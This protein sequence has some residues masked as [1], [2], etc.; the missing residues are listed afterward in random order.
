M[1]WQ[2][3][4]WV[5]ALS[6]LS[7]YN[8]ANA[9]YGGTAS[10]YLLMQVCTATKSATAPALPGVV[11]GDV[12]CRYTRPIAATDVP[13]YTM[14]DFAPNYVVAANPSCA[15]SFGPLVRTSAPV[16]LN[17]LTRMVTFNQSASTNQCQP[18]AQIGASGGGYGL[19]VQ[20]QDPVTGYASIMGSSGPNAI[21][22]NDAYQAFA[23]GATTGG[24]PS[25]PVCKTGNPFSSARFNNSWIVG[26]SPVSKTLPSPVQFASVQLQIIDPASYAVL[27]S[28]PAACDTPYVTG[29]HIW[30]T[31]WYTFYSGRMNVA[32]IAAHYSSSN[33][34]NTGPGNAQQ[35]ER[36]YWTHEFGL[37]R[38]EKWTRSDLLI[39]GADPKTLSSAL[40]QHATCAQKGL[41]AGTPYNFVTNPADSAVSGNVTMSTVNGVSQNV[42]SG[43]VT[44]TWYMTLCNDY[45]NIDR[46]ATG[47]PAP[48]ISSDYQALWTP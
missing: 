1:F 41:V 40:L 45:T 10:D 27:Q 36:T 17:G 34:S 5:V 22:L 20:S 35:M 48:A 18:A 26:S 37:S 30:R 21:S 38:W 23:N 12:G 11:P 2:L 24:M 42:V 7:G 3:G 33:T 13:P 6:V 46:T 9:Q 8:T 39:N 16:T 25:Q 28:G 29:F 43:G 19:S 32:T 15:G 4:G 44:H 31:D 47:Q 14:R